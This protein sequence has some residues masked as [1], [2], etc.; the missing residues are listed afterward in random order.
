MSWTWVSAPSA[1]DK[2]EVV[3]AAFRDDWL[4]VVIDA[5]RLVASARPEGSSAAL[6]MR[7]PEVRFVRARFRSAEELELPKLEV[8]ELGEF[9]LKVIMRT[10]IFRP[11]WFLVAFERMSV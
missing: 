2:A 3:S 9:A 1:T 10:A 8:S 5:D 11:N 4:N 7:M 6:L